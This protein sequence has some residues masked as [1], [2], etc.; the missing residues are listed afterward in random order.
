[1]RRRILVCE[2]EAE[3]RYTPLAYR[4][5][6]LQKAPS[7]NWYCLPLVRQTRIQRKTTPWRCGC[8]QNHP[9]C[10]RKVVLVVRRESSN[11]GMHP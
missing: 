2:V 8:C 11:K 9:D 7:R 4:R 1:M 3:K 6:A 5:L 10:G